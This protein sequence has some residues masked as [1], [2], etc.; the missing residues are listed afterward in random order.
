MGQV[1]DGQQE[2]RQQERRQ[3]RPRGQQAEQK[4]QGEREALLKELH[5]IHGGKA[6]KKLD[7]SLQNARVLYYYDVVLYYWLDGNYA[8]AAE[9]NYEISHAR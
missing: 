5:Y 4:V 3:R 1:P 7:L 9:H 8:L 2:Q 6:M